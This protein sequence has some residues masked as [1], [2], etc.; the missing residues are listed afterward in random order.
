MLAPFEFRSL[1]HTV[2]HLERAVAQ[3]EALLAFCGG[4][5]ARAVGAYFH[6]RHPH[7]TFWEFLPARPW[8][9]ARIYLASVLRKL[10]RLEAALEQYMT[11]HDVDGEHW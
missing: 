9:R 4:A 7:A 2:P 3:A 11:L 10:G 5:D 6:R 1:A 8:L